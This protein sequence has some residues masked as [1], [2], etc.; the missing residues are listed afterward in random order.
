MPDPDPALMAIMAGII[1][2]WLD[3]ALYCLP[4]IIAYRKHVKDCKTILACN[5]ALGWTI[6]G[7]FYAL[8]WA[9]THEV[10]D[11]KKAGDSK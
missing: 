9:L 6:V 8:F 2:F 7:W 4:S 3:L 10:E 11:S 5:L 1:G